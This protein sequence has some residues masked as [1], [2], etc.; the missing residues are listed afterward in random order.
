M[1][2]LIL[3]DFINW[4][5]ND[6][7]DKY[8]VIR[9]I[10]DKDCLERL[11]LLLELSVLFAVDDLIENITFIL[12]RY[13]LLPEDV[14]DIWLLAQ[15]LG[16]SLL[17]DL[18]LAVCLDRFTELPLHLIYK[19]SKQ[20]FLKLVG[21]INLRIEKEKKEEFDLSQ[22]VQEWMK[23]NKVKIISICNNLKLE[24]HNFL[25]E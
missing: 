7:H 25:K 15:E 24:Q 18:C 20:N 1:I 19:L 21:N 8:D 11:L 13:Y 4:I 2:I 5:D 10:F 12:E 23:I 6:E 3:Q 14:I 17:Q 16:L 22:I 9:K